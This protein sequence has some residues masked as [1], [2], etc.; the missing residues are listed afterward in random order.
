LELLREF[1]PEQW[2]T[3]HEYMVEM[4]KP[5]FGREAT[6]GTNIRKIKSEC[7]PTMMNRL[8]CSDE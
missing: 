6:D 3:I 8:F 5:Q 4:L 1:P 2:Q 7:K